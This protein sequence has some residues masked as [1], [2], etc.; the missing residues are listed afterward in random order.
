MSLRTRL[1]EE[2]TRIRGTL[3]GFDDK[4][5]KVAFTLSELGRKVED[6]QNQ[7]EGRQQDIEGRQR[8]IEGHF[9]RVDSG[10]RQ[11]E[12]KVDGVADGVRRLEGWAS[13]ATASP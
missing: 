11:L 13:D 8:V 4:Q 12:E 6:R 3:K 9:N 10:Q 5:D 1:D 2:I 7:I